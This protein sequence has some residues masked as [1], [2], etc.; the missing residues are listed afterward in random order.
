MYRKIVIVILCFLAMCLFGCN[1]T[2]PIETEPEETKQEKTEITMPTETKTSEPEKSETE[3][4]KTPTVGEKYELTVIESDFID[5]EFKSGSYE[6]GEVVTF[7][8]GIVLDANVYV[9]LNGEKLRSVDIDDGFY[10]FEFTMPNHD[11]ILHVT[12]NEY[13]YSSDLSF[14][15]IFWWHKDGNKYSYLEYE[16][17]KK[18]ELIKYVRTFDN[19]EINKVSK[20]F[21]Q[22]F[23]PVKDE[24]ITFDSY[25]R[26]RLDGN[27]FIVSGN[28]LVYED[29]FVRY[30][31]TINDESFSI[32]D[33]YGYTTYGFP[34]TF[35]SKGVYYND[36]KTNLHLALTFEFKE[37]KNL[38]YPI[39]GCGYKVDIGDDVISSMNII[40]DL[41]FTF[42]NRIYQIVYGTNFK[43]L[44]SNIP[45]YPAKQYLYFVY[46]EIDQFKEY[47][48]IDYTNIDS[49]QGLDII[50]FEKYSMYR[51][52]M[53]PGNR[54]HYA[55]EIQRL[56]DDYSISLNE[57]RK[58]LAT[59]YDSF[60][61]NFVKVFVVSET[62]TP[63]ELREYRDL[64]DEEIKLKNEII[65]ELC[66]NISDSLEAVSLTPFTSSGVIYSKAGSIVQVG[67]NVYPTQYEYKNVYY[68]SSNED[69]LTIDENG[70]ATLKNVGTAIVLVS[71]DGIISTLPFYISNNLVTCGD[72][73]YEEFASRAIKYDI[74]HFY[75][76][77]IGEKYCIRFV[78]PEGSSGN[79]HT[80]DM[81]LDGDT[82]Y[83]EYTQTVSGI[84][85]DMTCWLVYVY[86]S[87]EDYLNLEKIYVNDRLLE[88]SISDDVEG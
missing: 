84:T 66:L 67:F 87:F 70:L 63:A 61:L 38:N 47:I 58:I 33:I 6:A 3:G 25:D 82:L 20:I 62:V 29:E 14:S 35:R 18:N 68:K 21:K 42:N 22:K 50:V 19:E 85:C 13:Y 12:M 10:I 59:S 2:K 52:V 76:Y 72:I 30:T 11:S 65:K 8:V 26:Y 43:E 49:S 54:Y 75:K 81:R 80:L 28:Y 71:V 36:E 37:I 57:L 73:S 64:T 27:E 23:N 74:D 5:P 31:F 41:V 60:D 51:A 32:D 1:N 77:N 17:H 48:Q 40:N 86:V 16:S 24:I 56:I 79:R 45:T 53:Q 9:F 55:E 34:N 39:G 15:D 4:I 46:S 88:V 83:V 44:D 69:L 7:K 78:I